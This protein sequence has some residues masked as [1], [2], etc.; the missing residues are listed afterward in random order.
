MPKTKEKHP[1]TIVM[2]Y[3]KW[4]ELKALAERE[5]RPTAQM[6]RVIIERALTSDEG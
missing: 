4:L 1:F 3:E 2:A 6:A 5:S